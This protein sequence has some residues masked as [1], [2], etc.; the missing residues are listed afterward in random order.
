MNANPH[1]LA[2]DPAAQAFAEATSEPPFLFQL[3]PDDGRKAVDE[4]Q[5]S[6][7]YKPEV[8]EEWVTVDA[9]P[10]GSVKARIV[11]PF[12]ATGTLPVILYVHGAG[13]V[14]GDAHTHDRLVRDLAIGAHAAVVFTEYDRSPVARAAPRRS[15]L[16]QFLERLVPRGQVHR[17]RLPGQIAVDLVI[18]VDDEVAVRDRQGPVH[19]VQCE[20]P[21]P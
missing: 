16:V 11:R 7:I 19:S 17:Q 2:L 15:R 3:S 1:Q 4:V 9:G 13:W 20:H 6:D 21:D 5:S 18:L 14:F 10:T 8:H 12:G